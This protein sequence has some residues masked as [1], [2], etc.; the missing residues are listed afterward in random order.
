MG[1]F[2]EF[3]EFAKGLANYDCRSKYE[4]I[5]RMPNGPAIL[6]ELRDLVREMDAGRVR[7]LGLESFAKFMV[8]FVRK[9][10]GGLEFRSSRAGAES[11]VNRL[12][13]EIKSDE[14][15]KATKKRGR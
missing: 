4:Q 3:G 7:N 15:S 9:R 12:R 13:E 8:A 1:I 10:S 6:S 2:E 11:V 14:E 5:E